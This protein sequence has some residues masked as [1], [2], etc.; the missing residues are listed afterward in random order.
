MRVLIVDDEALALRRLE[1]LTR[2]VL[3]T[4]LL[5]V[6]STHSLR[7]AANAL[8]ARKFDVIF[9]DLNLA[10]EDGFK[11]LSENKT[12]APVIVVSAFPDRA[13]EAFDHAVLDFVPKPVDQE[14]LRIALQRL[15][16]SGSPAELQRLAVRNLGKV[17]LIEMNSIIRVS[18]ADD[19]SE[20]LLTD[21]RRLLCD[22]TLSE[23][24][25]RLPETFA[26]VHRSHVINWAHVTSVETAHARP[27]VTHVNGTSTPVSRRRISVVRDRFWHK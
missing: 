1:R 14:R 25:S 10:G 27:F 6:F 5:E 4:E 9:L 11:L 12:G 17:E 26:R 18:G 7:D 23:L 19:Y 2:T 13:I 8:A 20:I 21:G 15:P 24:E 3:S 22:Q 16:K